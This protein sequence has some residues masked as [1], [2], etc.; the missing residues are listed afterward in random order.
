MRSFLVPVLL[1][2]AG[3]AVVG[4]TSTT[5]QARAPDQLYLKV[6]VQQHGKTVAAPNLLGFEGRHIIVEKR[7]PQLGN[8][9]YRLVLTP[10]EEGSG[11]G[12]GFDLEFAGHKLGGRVGLL[13]GEERRVLLDDDTELKL[14]L[15]RVDSPEF[16]A[17]MLRTGR[18]TG[19]I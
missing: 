14:L 11:Y 7:T 12:V 4:C 1:S 18:P 16:R 10:K 19:Q 13:H 17:L 3:L 6:E 8:P 9:E 15:M 5:A 2:L